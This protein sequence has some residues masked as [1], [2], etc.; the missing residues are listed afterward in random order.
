MIKGLK[1]PKRLSA[2]NDRGGVLSLEIT[3]K[4]VIEAVLATIDVGAIPLP[5][6]ERHPLPNG[7]IGIVVDREHQ[8]EMVSGSLCINPRANEWWIEGIESKKGGCFLLSDV[9]KITQR[10]AA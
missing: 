8:G 1:V 10:E 4:E 3:Q 9:E 7:A 2:V 6:A 5:L